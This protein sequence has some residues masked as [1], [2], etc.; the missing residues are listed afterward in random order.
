MGAVKMQ[1]GTSALVKD[2]DWYRNVWLPEAEA[3]GFDS[4][5][6]GDS[7]SLWCDPFVTMTAAAALTRR[8]GIRVGVINPVTRHPAVV[9][10][11]MIGIQQLSQGRASLA[12][13]TGDSAVRNIS[14]PPAT[15][16]E[17]EEYCR[18]LKG[19]W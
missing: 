6:T 7:Q 11:A 16:A 2:F 13:A 4:I 17:L 12:V 15:F 9:A 3:A 19:L 14:E 10:S 5:G 1:F 8:P 18:A